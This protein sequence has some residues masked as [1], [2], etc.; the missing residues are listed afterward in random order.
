MW[1]DDKYMS[2]DEFER[3]YQWYLKEIYE[4]KQEPS[5]WIIGPVRRI[6]CRGC[7]RVFY[8]SVHSKIYCNYD[9]CSK[10]YRKRIH[11]IRMKLREQHCAEC[12]KEF[13]P[14]RTDAK[15]CSNACRQKHFR[16]KTVSAKFAEGDT[17]IDPA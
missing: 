9:T 15:F 6:F 11:R 5:G 1:L 13:I 2:Y 7:G 10:L 12:G 16:Q 8:T 3:E 14:K 17:P 4:K